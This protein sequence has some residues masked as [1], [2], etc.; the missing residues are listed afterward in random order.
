MMIANRLLKLRRASADVEIAIRLHMPEQT[1]DGVWL[2]KYEI[3]WPHGIWKHAALGIDSIQSIVLALQMIG[4][5]I[6][7]SEY[8]KS[9]DLMLEAPMRGY[10]FPVPKSLRDLLIGDDATFF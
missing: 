9:G 7:S 1:A 5:E 10:G 3:D 2:C 8:H 6:Y 4:A